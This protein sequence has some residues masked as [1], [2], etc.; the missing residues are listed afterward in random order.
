M[1]S[2]LAIREGTAWIVELERTTHRLAKPIADEC[3]EVDN[4]VDEPGVTGHKSELMKS[5]ASRMTWRGFSL[6][7]V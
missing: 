2:A 5:P 7:T 6:T 3:N 1:S 4:L